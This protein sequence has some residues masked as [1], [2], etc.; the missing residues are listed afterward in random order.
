MPDAGHAC[1]LLA[2]SAGVHGMAGGQAIDLA[3]VG[4]AL[5]LPEQERMHR[6]KTGALIRAAVRLGAACGRP[7]AASQEAALDAYAHAAGLAFQ[8][9]DDVLDVEGSA[10]AIGKTAGKDA[11]QGKPTFVSLRGLAGAKAHA[12]A[13]RREAQAALVPFDAGAR[14]LVELADWI[15][16]RRH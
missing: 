8:V 12:E 10:A 13:L 6:L 3:S 16:L 7:L 4:A 1:A 15:V 14:R 5:E 2:Q 9:I 11:A